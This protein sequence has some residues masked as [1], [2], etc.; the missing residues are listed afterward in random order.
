MAY[1]FNFEIQGTLYGVI[2]TRPGNSNWR[3]YRKGKAPFKKQNVNATEQF[4]YALFAISNNH[5]LREKFLLG[6]T[7]RL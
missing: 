5:R 4:G 3:N 2:V 6:E 7:I 1:R